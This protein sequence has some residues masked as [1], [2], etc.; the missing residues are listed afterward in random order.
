MAVE[1]IVSRIRMNK[2]E[3]VTI[4]TPETHML[5]KG[6]ILM[7]SNRQRHNHRTEGDEHNSPDMTKGLNKEDMTVGM[8]EAD[9]RRL[10][11]AAVDTVLMHI[12][13]ILYVLL[14]LHDRRK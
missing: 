6:G 1:D 13:F 2:K 9:L 4:K 3:A 7:P 10:L 5:S 14:T 11:L 8:A 12:T